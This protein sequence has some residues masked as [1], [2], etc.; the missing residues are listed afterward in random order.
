MDATCRELKREFKRNEAVCGRVLTL[1]H[2]ISNKVRFRIICM[3]AR[4]EFCVR[5][6]MEVI[7]QGTL[8]NISQ[9]L[10]ML[11][12]AGILQKRREEKRILYSL[13]DQRLRGLVKFLSAQFMDKKIGQ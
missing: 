13:R 7:N 2:L 8:S 5:D 1:F 3:L 12:L 11:T 4:G 9:Q 6:I 10:K